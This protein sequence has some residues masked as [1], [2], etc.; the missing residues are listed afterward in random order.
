MTNST[1]AHTTSTTALTAI[2]SH[3]TQAGS[4]KSDILNKPTATKDKA[5]VK[6][7]T[8]ESSLDA[9]GLQQLSITQ[10]VDCDLNVR[11]GKVS[12]ADDDALYASIK[13]HGLLQN[14]LVLPADEQ[15]GYAV[16]GGGR[17]LKQLRR[18]VKDGKLTVAD[19]VP[20][21][22]L[23]ASEAE[24]FA[25]ELSLSENFVRANMHPADEFSAFAELVNQGSS[26]AQVAER[27][28]VTQKFVKQR[29][30]LSSVAP[31]ILDA[32]RNG[33]TTLDIVMC[34]SIADT[35]QQLS[36]W[37]ECKDR[38]FYN[39]SALRNMLTPQALEGDNYLVEFVGKAAY[40][41]A[42]GVTT[43]DLFEDTVY[44]DDSELVRT[45]ATAKLEKQAEQLTQ[46]GWKWTKVLLQGGYC[47][48]EGYDKLEV[49]K[50]G[51]EETY[52]ADE[53]ALAG[54][55]VS[56]RQYGGEVVIHKGLVA[57]E[58]KKAWALVQESGKPAQAESAT[59]P[60][61]KSG[62]SNALK[63]DLIAQRLIIS[64]YALMNNP[65]VAIDALHFS[66][67]LSAFS[68]NHQY[69]FTPLYIKHSET[70]HIP[71]KGALSDNK[72]LELIEQTKAEFDIAWFSLPTV[73]E[74]FDAF[75]QLDT[76]EKHK[77]V[78]Y[79]AALSLEPSLLGSR[80]HVECVINKLAITPSDFWR[81]TK[82]TFFKR[83]SQGEL[84]DIAKPVMSELWAQQAT[85]LKKK[86]VV[87][88]VD[89]LVN[90]KGEQLTE[91]QQDYFNTWMPTGF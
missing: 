43:T 28:G 68:A 57:K 5:V 3:K 24:Q 56:L 88:Q 65:T 52:N 50:E 86:E 60:E 74:R 77:Q 69:E 55:V 62:Y 9:G 12:K 21:K 39:L 41:K 53:M 70:K 51:D 72:A 15:G 10:L 2:A 34:Y 46:D 35:E 1:A 73:T 79:A 6:L 16:I 42:G 18:L 32:Y 78:A 31:V 48:T 13:A 81:P 29:M 59:A 4:S 67:C 20:V 49:V 17:R 87:I 63:D 90:G 33:E 38:D 7:V 54:C 19:K 27:F 30:K 89:E 91:K 75:C 45:L 58:D 82:E 71:A 80:E 36:V 64:K 40:K 26:F 83:I 14:L 8:G 66:M 47:D 84:I 76:V 11:K 85:S 23:T 25:S 61:D 22:V 44:F 37:A